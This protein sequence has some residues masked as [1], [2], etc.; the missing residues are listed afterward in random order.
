MRFRILPAAL[1]A[2]T[3]A[4]AVTA[5]TASAASST[6][7][8]AAKPPVAAKR[9]SYQFASDTATTSPAEW[10]IRNS[11]LSFSDSSQ[12]VGKN[13]VNLS[14]TPGSS[15]YADSGVIVALG[16]L[17]TLFNASGTY[18]AP[19]IVASSDTAVN[20][21]FGTDGS[22]TGYLSFNSAGVYEGPG[23]DNLASI[24]G[25]SA[26]FTTFA[27]GNTTIGLSGT[28]TMEAVLA[29]Y[30]ANTSGTTN[31][32]VWAWIGIDGASH[33]TATVTSVN[34]TPLVTV[35]S[36]VTAVRACGGSSRYY[37]RLRNT[38]G[39][40]T[41]TVTYAIYHKGWITQ[42]RY[43]L[44]AGREHTVSTR[45]GSNFRYQYSDGIG[46]TVTSYASV[47]SCQR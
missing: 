15:G 42:G 45:T 43:A 6:S 14:I 37:F 44:K 9:G 36:V 2:A 26:D 11:P 34:G 35:G 46:H 21:Y 10:I 8:A 16:R 38:T 5:G 12:S 30:K 1:A 39:G 4:L 13:G 32:E 40:R 23:G 28:M 20:Y 41:V 18:V 33:E 31:P 3:L 47:K 24:S 27:Q 19:K 7:R 22:T 29:A 25:D 17:D